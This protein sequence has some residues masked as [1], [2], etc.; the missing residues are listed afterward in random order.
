MAEGLRPHKVSEIYI[1]GAPVHNY[2]SDISTTLDTKVLALHA[3]VGQ[4]GEFFSDIE[5]M[6]RGWSAELGKRYGV[7][8]AEEFHRTTNL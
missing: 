1:M 2:G 7:A 5:H 4:V 3:H 6:L 8:Y